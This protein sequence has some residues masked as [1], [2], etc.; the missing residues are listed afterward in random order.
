M[1]LGG[2][3]MK[4]WKQTSPNSNSNSTDLS[5][6]GFSEFVDSLNYSPIFGR[7]YLTH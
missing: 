6:K 7:M 2:I 5:L 4:H 1:F 3:E